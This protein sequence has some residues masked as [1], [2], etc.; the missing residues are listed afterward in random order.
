ML[1][2]MGYHDEIRTKTLMVIFLKVL[3]YQ[4]HVQKPLKEKKY[5]VLGW[6]AV[7]FIKAVHN[8]QTIIHLKYFHSFEYL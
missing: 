8:Y 4:K 7:T 1:R 5:E 6:L 3:F 2:N